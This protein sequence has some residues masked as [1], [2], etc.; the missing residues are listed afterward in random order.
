MRYLRY[1]MGTQHMRYWRYKMETQYMRYLRYRMYFYKK[2][3]I[4]LVCGIQ[5][6]GKRT[7]LDGK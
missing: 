4:I 5:N 1:K 2:I 6:L 3:L 7:Q